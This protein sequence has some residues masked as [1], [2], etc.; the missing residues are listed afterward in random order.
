MLRSCEILPLQYQK[1]VGFWMTDGRV[2]EIGFLV[3]IGG[4]GPGVQS[5]IYG[6]RQILQPVVI[7]LSFSV[8]QGEVC[9]HGK[10]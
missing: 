5:R 1:R 7:N 4:E 9:I 3:V 10:A 2:P 6:I 8:H